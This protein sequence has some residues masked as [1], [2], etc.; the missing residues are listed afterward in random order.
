MVQSC[1]R[2]FS[3]SSTRASSFDEERQFCRQRE[4]TTKTHGKIKAREN[5][6]AGLFSAFLKINCFLL[7]VDRDLNV[8]D[9]AFGLVV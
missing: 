9:W 3:S 7:E 5:A 6:L 8:A 4:A 1:S 2:C